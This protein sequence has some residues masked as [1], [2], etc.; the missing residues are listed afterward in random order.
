MHNTKWTAFHGAPLHERLVLPTHWACKL[1]ISLSKKELL[2]HVLAY[3][4]GRTS[5]FQ[6]EGGPGKKNFLSLF[7]PSQGCFG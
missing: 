3:A 7:L 6:G 2:D 1:W 5:V 4:R